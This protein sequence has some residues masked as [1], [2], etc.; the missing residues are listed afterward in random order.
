MVLWFSF[1]D[2]EPDAA[3]FRQSV[4]TNQ[5]H[6]PA[7][8]MASADTYR[9][10]EVMSFP[11]MAVAGSSRNPPCLCSVTDSGSIGGLSSQD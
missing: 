5:A 9:Q 11:Q 4:R 6:L 1:L 10:E 7:C 2:D 8:R 3:Q